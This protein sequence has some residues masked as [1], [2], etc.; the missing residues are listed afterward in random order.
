MA[1]QTPPILSGTLTKRGGKDL[2]G[3]NTWRLRHFQLHLASEKKFFHHQQQFNDEEE[4]DADE[5]EERRAFNKKE[6]STLK[7]YASEPTHSRQQPKGM[8]EVTSKSTVVTLE[9]EKILEEHGLGSKY[10]GKK[11][12]AFYS[13]MDVS[14]KEI[15]SGV[16]N[17]V[18]VCE[19]ENQQVLQ[20]WV[21]AL[22]DAIARERSRKAKNGEKDGNGSDDESDTEVDANGRKRKSG[23]EKKNSLQRH[24]TKH[25]RRSFFKGA[26]ERAGLTGPLGGVGVPT[27]LEAVW[28]QIAFVDVMADDALGFD[29]RLMRIRDEKMAV[30]ETL[31]T[32]SDSCST[33]SRALGSLQFPMSVPETNAIMEVR[34]SLDDLTLLCRQIPAGTQDNNAFTAF[35]SVFI[36]RVRSM[37]PG[38]LLMFPGG[39]STQND[40][41]SRALIYT[42]Q[43]LQGS[44]VFS[45]TNTGDGLEY[46]PVKADP[47][48]DGFLYGLT[49]QLTEIPMDMC[50]D[51]STWALLL[52]PIVH[53]QTRTLR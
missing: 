52:R 12:F 15:N 21:T 43:R 19:C 33:I 23:G 16:S 20:S 26:L 49:T 22:S 39:W 50:L 9:D 18:V 6:K 51:S 30:R 17:S 24:Q 41:K 37:R 2:Y 14:A 46:H 28:E 3:K 11:L 7:Y 36:D 10:L 31:E 47:S 53:P 34:R 4:N 5:E 8:F 25:A 35:L 44:F 40:G 29:E 1:D 13:K 27:H 42:L 32:M 45:V 38:A 48:S